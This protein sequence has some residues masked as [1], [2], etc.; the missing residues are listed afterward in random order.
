MRID[1][2]LKVARVLKKREIGKELALNNRLFVNDKAVK[3]A[4]EVKV[5]DKIKIEFGNRIIKIRV[6]DIRENASKQDALSMYEVVEEG[7]C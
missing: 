7:N 6:L 2:Y 3:A 1:K 5:G 4:Y